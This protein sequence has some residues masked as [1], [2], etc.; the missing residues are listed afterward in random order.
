MKTLFDKIAKA[1]NQFS[2]NANLN[3]TAKELLTYPNSCLLDIGISR[4][5]LLKGAKGYPWKEINTNDIYSV[6][7]NNT[8][9]ID[10]KIIK[11]ANTDVLSAA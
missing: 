9:T 11:P 10:T 8:S 4:H 6:A 5:L 2:I 3:R 1:L 7:L